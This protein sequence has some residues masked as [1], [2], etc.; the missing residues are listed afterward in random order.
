MA[1]LGPLLLLLF[2]LGAGSL[3]SRRYAKST[4]DIE[5]ERLTNKVKELVARAEDE[6]NLLDPEVQKTFA[7]AN[8]L[9]ILAIHRDTWRREFR[10]VCQDTPLLESLEKNAPHVLPW[11]QARLCIINLA[12]QA[13][14]DADE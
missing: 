4:A 8:P 3:S 10:E 9:E 12:E 6:A 2:V 11:L 5:E 7:A 13:F 14:T 1:S